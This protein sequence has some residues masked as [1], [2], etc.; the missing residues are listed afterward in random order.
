MSR[1]FKEEKEINIERKL[2]LLIHLRKNSPEEEWIK[3]DERIKK[4]SRQYFL[5]TS[6]YF[7]WEKSQNRYA[8]HDEIRKAIDEGLV[9]ENI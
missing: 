2:S 9:R 4:L 8:N 5:Q 6:K 3:Y 1:I 7:D